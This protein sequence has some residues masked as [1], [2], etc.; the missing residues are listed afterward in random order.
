MK[1]D[2]GC[3]MEFY[4]SKLLLSP[5]S[6]VVADFRCFASMFNSSVISACSRL[7]TDSTRE[8]NVLEASS[9]TS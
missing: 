4:K 8:Q 9:Q 3:D 1:P 5:D 2:A 7:Y 6:E